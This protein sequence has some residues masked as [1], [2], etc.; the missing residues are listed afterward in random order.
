MY[1]CVLSLLRDVVP[2]L[3]FFFLWSN[4]FALGFL[5]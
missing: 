5:G 2:Y 4:I 3:F 1:A